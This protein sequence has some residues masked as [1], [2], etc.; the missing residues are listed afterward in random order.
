MRDLRLVGLS[1]DRQHVV[2]CSDGGERFRVAAD[3]RLRVALRG[4]RA[5]LGQL[6]IQMDNALR[7]RDIQARIRA[8]ESPE[9]VA[10]TA[11]APLER[12]MGYAVPVLAEREH[13]CERAQR[14]TLRRK[15]TSGPTRLLGDAVA[16]ELRARGVDPST[17]MWDSWRRDD[18]R[19]AVTVTPAG[20]GTATYTFDLPGRYAVAAD[21]EARALVADT[22]PV[23][24]P[25]EMAI[26]SAVAEAE[27]G[28]SA[29]TRPV[30]GSDEPGVTPIR[31]A[32]SLRPPAPGD[33]LPLDTAVDVEPVG[34][35][36]A[37]GGDDIDALARVTSDGPASGDPSS[38]GQR[39]RRDRRRTSVPSWD[40]IMLGG[41]PPR[42]D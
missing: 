33:E 31:Q 16:E 15:Y 34:H 19:W 5:R 27:L 37:V 23:E 4:D 26:A 12:I 25:T 13:V 11:Q 38:S 10:A 6:E 7:P 36:R 2:L 17:A 22:P 3:E 29:P 21:D 35:Q 32:R 24:D 9:A 39:R 42:R 28:V 1:E 20:G 30:E 40:E 14:A 41:R 18:G 8:G